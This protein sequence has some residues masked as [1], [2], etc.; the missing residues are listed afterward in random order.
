MGRLKIKNAAVLLLVVA[1]LRAQII[2][3]LAVANEK[4]S[5]VALV[6]MKFEKVPED[7]QNI[8]LWRMTA[9]LESHESLILTKPDAVRIAYGPE[10]LAEL[11]EKQGAESFGAFAQKYQFDYVFCGRLTNQSDD[12]N[13]V[14]L[15]GDLVRY[16]TATGLINDYEIDALYEKFGNNLVKFREQYVTSIVSTQDSGLNPWPIILVGGLVVAGAIAIGTGTVGFG[17]NAG[18]GSTQPK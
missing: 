1:L 10:K 11:L 3:S 2:P 8:L 7:V 6:G 14:W 15:V 9:I 16:D 12:K 13:Q 17:G 4:K 5:R 18:S